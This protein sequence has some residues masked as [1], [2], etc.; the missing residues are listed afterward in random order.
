M[1]R[2]PKLSEVSG[3]KRL[4]D[5]AANNGSVLPRPI[6]ELY[7]SV[8]DFFVYVDDQGVRGCTALHI[9]LIDLAEIR[10]LVVD[11]SLRGKAVGRKLVEACLKEAGELD[12]SRIYALTRVPDFFLNLGFSE[13]DKHELPHKVFN[14][15]IKCPL[16]PDC[17]ET[18]MIYDLKEYTPQSL[19]DTFRKGKVSATD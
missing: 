1:I 12:L 2:K 9:D 3:I 10:S 8:R 17:D 18:A 15:C 4:V 19:E 14:D 7:E 16:F 5:I 11:E 13:V 6:I